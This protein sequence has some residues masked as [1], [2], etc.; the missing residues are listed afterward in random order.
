MDKWCVGRTLRFNAIKLRQT[1][2]ETNTSQVIFYI[3]YNDLRGMGLPAGLNF[4]LNLMAVQRRVNQKIRC[5][6]GLPI[7]LM[8]LIPVTVPDDYLV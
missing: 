8:A 7:R 6:R 5:T 1:C 4:R 2:E 3:F